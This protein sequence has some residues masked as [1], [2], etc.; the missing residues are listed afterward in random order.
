MFSN[1]SAVGI[2]ASWDRFNEIRI[3]VQNKAF[4]SMLIFLS[5][6]L[7]SEYT[8]GSH[9]HFGFLLDSE[10][11]HRDKNGIQWK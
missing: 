10:R 5:H 9:R 1:E 6:H 4:Y 3:T 7:F 11:S 8:F 2:D